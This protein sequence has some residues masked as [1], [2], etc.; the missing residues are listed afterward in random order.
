MANAQIEQIRIMLKENPVIPEGASLEQM[1]SGFDSMGGMFP[2]L[3]D[4]SSIPV[5]AGGVDSEWF[6][7]SG[8]EPS[9]VLLY[10]HGSDRC[11]RIVP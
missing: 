7:V 8:G 10:L 4:V 1:R 9:R 11:N 5:D 2:S 6:D 3:D